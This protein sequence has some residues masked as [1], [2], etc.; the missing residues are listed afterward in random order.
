MSGKD[1]VQA[2]SRAGFVFAHQD[3]SHVVLKHPLRRCRTTVPVH[4]GQDL[5]PGTLRGILR[6]AGLSVEEFIAL[7]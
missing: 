5:R 7:L 2:L 3:G 4:A 6:D 1:T